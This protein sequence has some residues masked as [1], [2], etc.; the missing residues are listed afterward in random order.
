MMHGDLLICAG[1]EGVLCVILPTCGQVKVSSSAI[2]CLLYGIPNSI[3]I[4]CVLQYGSEID[5]YS[6]TKIP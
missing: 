5:F 6:V 2:Y 4:E 1:F 3:N